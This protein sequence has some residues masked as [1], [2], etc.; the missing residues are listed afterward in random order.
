M[1]AV[2]QPCDQLWLFECGGVDLTALRERREV[3]RSS[4]R[5]RR[6]VFAYQSDWRIFSKWCAL[7]GRD[8]FPTAPE[9]VELY[10]TW[11]LTEKKRKVTTAERHVS[12][13]AHRHHAAGLESPSTPALRNILL[14][15]RR[16][17]QEQP[18]G[19]TAL[20]PRNLVRI[21]KKCDARTALGAR[22]RALVVL[23]FATAFRRAEL[24]RLRLSE[25]GFDRRGLAVLL[26][27]SKRDQEGK[28]KLFAVWA[29]K[30]A[31]TD[32]VRVLKAWLRY[33]GTWEGPLFC[34]VQTGNTITRRPLSGEAVNEA[35]K[36]AIANVGIDPDEYGAHSLRSGAIST[37]AE[38]GRS[39]QELIGLSGHATVQSLKPYIRRARLFQGRNP[40][41]GV[42]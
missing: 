30:R 6:T 9:T 34:R 25:V 13:I 3:L 12:A 36:R 23:G 10:V 37:S 1:S 32:P 21:A 42:L 40:L 31:C 14:T 27:Y 11:M 38:L 33:R 41:A 39:D 35:I 8:P 28:G 2:S 17:R 29:G 26:R 5:A 22:D 7:A 20:D 18:Q 15:V 24:A 4:P 19:K 16:D